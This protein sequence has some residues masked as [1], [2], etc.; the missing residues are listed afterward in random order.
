MITYVAEPS[1]LVDRRGAGSLDSASGIAY[2][3]RPGSSLRG[4]P[5]QMYAFVAPL[6][7]NKTDEFRQFVGE[8]EGARKQEYE[9]SRKAAGFRRETIFLQKTAKGDMVVVI[10]E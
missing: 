4:S 8:L 10:Q 7:P 6:Q 2:L 1:P 9:D 3:S 5:M